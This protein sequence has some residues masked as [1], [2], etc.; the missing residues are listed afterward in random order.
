MPLTKTGK[1]VKAA[2]TKQYG[3]KKGEEVFYATM[4]KYGKKWHK[5]P[6]TY[7]DTGKSEA[8]SRRAYKPTPDNVTRAETAKKAGGTPGAVQQSDGTENRRADY[9]TKSASRSEP[10]SGKTRW[11]GVDSYGESASETP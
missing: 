10:G 8:P 2:M 11:G 4:N 3:A 1:K 6:D 9:K 5:S 7:D